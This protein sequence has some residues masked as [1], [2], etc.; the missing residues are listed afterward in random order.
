MGDLQEG[1]F[2]SGG[3]AFIPGD[4]AY[5][6]FTGESVGILNYQ[7]GSDMYEVRRCMHGKS[8]GNKYVSE[9]Y[10]AFEL[11][12]EVEHQLRRKEEMDELARSLIGAGV[13]V[14]DDR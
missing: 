2:M 1:G 8:H 11:E 4:L 3:P 14:L 5:I 12:S 13:H 9:L 7:S 10:H 6:R